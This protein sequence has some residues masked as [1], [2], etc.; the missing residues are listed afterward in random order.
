M[1]V[2]GQGTQSDI[3]MARALALVNALN[4]LKVLTRGATR[5]S[6]ASADDWQHDYP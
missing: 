1:T 5:N 2:A 6:G 4:R 3:V